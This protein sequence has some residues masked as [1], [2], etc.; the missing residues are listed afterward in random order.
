MKSFSS[1]SLRGPATEVQTDAVLHRLLRDSYL[2]REHGLPSSGAK[3][4]AAAI[5][6]AGL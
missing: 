6:P 2:A 1:S 3:A 5:T 4:S